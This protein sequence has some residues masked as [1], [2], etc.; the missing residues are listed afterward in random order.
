MDLVK[1]LRDELSIPSKLP[2]TI[3]ECAD[4]LYTTSALR[5]ALG[6]Q[7]ARLSELETRLENE[8][9]DKLPKENATGIAGKVAR[10]RIIPFSVPQVDTENGG[11]EKLWK[12]IKKQDGVEGFAVLGRTLNKKNVE[13]LGKQVPG[14]KNFNGKKVSCTKV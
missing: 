2:K 6:K 11:W 9:I 3:A 12:W 7:L 13:E 14:V 4:L 10:V 5:L 1:T 8:I